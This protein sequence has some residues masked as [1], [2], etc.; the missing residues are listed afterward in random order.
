MFVVICVDDFI[1]TIFIM[2]PTIEILAARLR[3]RGTDAEDEIQ[4]RMAVDV[5][6]IQL[7]EHYDHKI[8]SATREEDFAALVSIY[9]STR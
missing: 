2:P 1:I 7:G 5:E 9:E 8:V 3:G 4:R 6:E